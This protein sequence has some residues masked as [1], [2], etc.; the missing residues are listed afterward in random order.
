M[1]IRDRNKSDLDLEV[2]T[3]E[4]EQICG[5]KV[6]PVSAKEEQGIELLE[7]EIKKLFYHGDL[8]F[9]CLLYTSFVGTVFGTVL[10]CRFFVDFLRKSA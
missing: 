6:I 8:S 2:G 9:N 5:H 10:F 7:Q 1:C 4:L 3:A